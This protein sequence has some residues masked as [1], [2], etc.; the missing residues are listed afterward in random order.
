MQLEQA[1]FTSAVTQYAQ[2][3]HLVSRSPG[4]DEQLTQT[5][6]LWGP[7]HDSLMH[8]EPSA[9]SLNC[10]PAG[11]DRIAI[12]RTVY[13]GAEYSDRG[14]F[15]TLTSLLVLQRRQLDGYDDCPLRFAR[16][17]LALGHLR[18]FQEP[19]EQ[20][21]TLQLPDGTLVDRR[22]A[23]ALNGAQ[24]GLVAEVL[25]ALRSGRRIAVVGADDPLPLLWQL[26]EQ[27]TGVERSQ[28]S[29]TTGLKP[30]IQRPF[31][32]HFLPGSDQD[33]AEQL[34]DLGIDCFRSVA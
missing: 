24:S 18:T 28:L 25:R 16:T 34:D 19:G 5:L 32:L 22:P 30:S 21:P 29:F 6:T 23:P 1:I 3:Y 13:W 33:V 20:L 8:P 4:I 12:S 9:V 10:F 17:A 7:T 14:G 2:G 11:N 27:L 31:Q 26:A 15:R